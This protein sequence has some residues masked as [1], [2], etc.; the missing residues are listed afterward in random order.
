MIRRCVHC[1][2]PLRD[3]SDFCPTCHRILKKTEMRIGPNL[4]ERTRKTLL[5]LGAGIAFVLFSFWSEIKDLFTG[6]EFDR[7]LPFVIIALLFIIAI[8]VQLL[9]SDRV[10]EAEARARQERRSAQARPTRLEEWL[11][12]H[13]GQD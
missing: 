4:P 12:A 10:S 3:G 8:A 9:R 13:S 2:T 1:N 6:P 11:K 5:Q 7:I